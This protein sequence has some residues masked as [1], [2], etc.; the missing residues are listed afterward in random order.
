M[1][2]GSSETM[3]KASILDAC[4]NSDV[5]SELTENEID[6]ILDVLINEQFSDTRK[7]AQSTLEKLIDK[8]SKRLVK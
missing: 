6:L 5:L 7:A 1:T 4:K 2:Q 3:M 8:I